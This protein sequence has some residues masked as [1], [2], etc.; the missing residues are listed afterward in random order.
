M[1]DLDVTCLTYKLFTLMHEIDDLKYTL[2][3]FMKG[4]NTFDTLL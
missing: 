2:T 1:L 3:R 4:K